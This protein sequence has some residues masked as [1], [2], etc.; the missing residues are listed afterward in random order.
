[1]ASPTQNMATNNR[2]PSIGEVYMVEFDGIGSVQSGYRPA[3]IFQNNVGN[4]YSPNVVVLPITSALKKM[5]QPTH[6]LIAANGSGMKKDS[7]VLCENP[8]CIPKERIG[9]YI[10]TLSEKYMK[11]VAE[12]SLLANS[13]ISYLDM[14]S[15]KELIGKACKLNAVQAN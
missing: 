1:M 10:T 3:L 4:R 9:K 6:V 8:Q 15:I 12:A 7:I 13:A 5:S 2:Y 11:K 14:S